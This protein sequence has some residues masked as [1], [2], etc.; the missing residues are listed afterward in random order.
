M[1]GI[2]KVAETS[3]LTSGQK[4][5]V[6]VEGKDI[7]LVNVGD[8]YYALSDKCPHMGGSLSEGI[9][10]GTTITCPRHG[11]KFDIK[12]GDCIGE[13]KIAFLKIKVKENRKFDVRVEG[14]DVLVDVS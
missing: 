13:A 10:D 2:I 7:L 8:T 1:M 5:K 9:L 12:T 6:T 14:S 4:K 11:A 3:E